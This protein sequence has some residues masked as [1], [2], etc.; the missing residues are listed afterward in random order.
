MVSGI[1]Y[2]P[3]ALVV[4]KSNTLPQFG[5]IKDIII[6]DV[7]DCYFVFSQLDTLCFNSHYHSYEVS[8]DQSFLSVV[9]PSEMIDS[10]VLHPNTVSSHS[11]VTLKYQ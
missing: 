7:D 10:H 8:Y 4:V 11:S 1:L 3:G 6:V 9:R 2:K 5:L